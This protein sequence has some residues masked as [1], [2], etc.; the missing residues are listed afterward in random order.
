MILMNNYS[1]VQI[2]EKMYQGET[3]ICA[4]AE[5]KF[6]RGLKIGNKLEAIYRWSKSFPLILIAIIAT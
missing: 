4:M 2:C 3:R 6:K 1:D 5:I